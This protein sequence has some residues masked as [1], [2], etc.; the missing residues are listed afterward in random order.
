VTF[1]Q[2]WHFHGGTLPHDATKKEVAALAWAAAMESRSTGLKLTR[3][4][5]RAAR[6]AASTAELSRWCQEQ[7]DAIDLGRAGDNKT[8]KDSS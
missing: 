6:S 1:K 2:W 3:E 7:I 8:R 4:M 5:W